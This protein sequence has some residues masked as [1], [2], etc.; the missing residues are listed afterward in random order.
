MKF[1]SWTFNGDQVSERARAYLS[2]RCGVGNTQTIGSLSLTSH[3]L[4]LSLYLPYLHHFISFMRS[5]RQ[6]VDA[7]EVRYRV[8]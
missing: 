7:L 4:R 3:P 8:K 2:P 1:G 5:L 6:H